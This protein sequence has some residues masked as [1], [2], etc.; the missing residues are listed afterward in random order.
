MLL[1]LISLQLR[2]KLL[3]EILSVFQTKFIVLSQNI[4]SSRVKFSLFPICFKDL[5]I[6]FGDQT[7]AGQRERENLKQMPYPRVEHDAELD[8]KTLRS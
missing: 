1:M 8:P 5:S 7:G 4:Q 3:W 2:L 6:Y